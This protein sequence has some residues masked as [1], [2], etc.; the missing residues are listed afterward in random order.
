MH[1]SFRVFLS[2]VL[3]VI[4][5]AAVFSQTPGFSD[6]A[7]TYKLQ[8]S[9]VVEI[10]YR[11]TPEFNQTVTVQSDGFASLQLIGNLKLQGLTLDQMKSA[12]LE[13]ASTRLK[14]PE[15]TLVLKEFERPYFVVGGQ[16]EKPGRFELHGTVT[17]LE[18]IAIA[19]GFKSDKAK[20]SQ[21]VLFRKAG[22]DTF[23]TRIIDLKAAMTG[24]AN[25]LN[26]DLHSGDML[27][28]PQN[29]ISKIERIIKMVNV[30][31]YIPIF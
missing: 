25:E 21:V 26:I 12:L 8:P 23:S 19:G 1:L 17:A 7:P 13:K 10:D 22:A 29:Q 24:S 30:G 3:L 4:S 11:Y 28:V 14:D 5:E 16:V 27:M 15:V 2:T 18:A 31:A 6:H 20:H 9:D